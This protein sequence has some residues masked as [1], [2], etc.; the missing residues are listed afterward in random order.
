MKDN[1]DRIQRAAE[2]LRL[3]N[4]RHYESPAIDRCLRDINEAVAAL[5]E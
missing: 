1:L 3:I 2:E 5:K 4:Y